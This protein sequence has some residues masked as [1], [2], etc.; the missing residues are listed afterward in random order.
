M[1]NPCSSRRSPQLHPPQL[2]DS[3]LVNGVEPELPHVPAP[4]PSGHVRRVE[5]QDIIA[6]LAGPGVEQQDGGPLL[7]ESRLGVRRP[8]ELCVSDTR[9]RSAQA[10]TEFMDA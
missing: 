3:R 7:G 9:Y 6:P 4:P 5:A 2:D 10:K 1:P 8:E